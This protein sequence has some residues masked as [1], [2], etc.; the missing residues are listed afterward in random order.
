ML[1]KKLFFALAYLIAPV[2][3]IAQFEFTIT[4]AVLA[5]LALASFPL[6][7]E[8]FRNKRLPNRIIYPT[9]LV[10]LAVITMYSLAQSSLSLFT[11]PV[12]RAGIAF[13]VAL[14]LYFLARG[15]F[16]AGDVKLV[17]LAG[18]PLGIFTP[19]HI[20]AAAIFACLGVALYSLALLVT[21]QA[22]TKSTVAFG[23]FIILG[24]WLAILL[25]N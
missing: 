8:D 7:R 22:S 3:V 23:P 12:G 11:Q 2:M 18:L 1:F 24:S 16:G 10:T 17:F 4:S 25:F 9:T 15:G 5:P 13:L 21:K 20:L 14:A 19:A 6:I